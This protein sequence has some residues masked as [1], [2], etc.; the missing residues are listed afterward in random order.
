MLEKDKYTENL[1]RETLYWKQMVG[2]SYADIAKL[3]GVSSRGFIYDFCRGKTSIGY[4][5]GRR[6]EIIT[7]FMTSTEFAAWKKGQKAKFN[8]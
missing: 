1:R 7:D 2:A 5:P 8:E 6:L 4:E 3:I